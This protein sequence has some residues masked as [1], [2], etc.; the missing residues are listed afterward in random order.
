MIKYSRVVSSEEGRLLARAW[1][2]HFIE[3]SAMNLEAVK[4]LFEKSIHAMN[5][6]DPIED[7]NQDNS[8]EKH[9]NDI[10]SS[11]SLRNGFNRKQNGNLSSK[12]QS[13]KTICIIS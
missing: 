5:Y 12:E 10:N 6:I 8:I 13:S 11:S 2:V 3:A 7:I 1:N 9:T 4:K